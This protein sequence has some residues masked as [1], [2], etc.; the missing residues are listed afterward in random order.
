MLGKAPGVVLRLRSGPL[1]RGD[2]LSP[3]VREQFYY[4]GIPGP[5]AGDQLP[6]P[7]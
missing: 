6:A 3:R 1:V 2:S 4:V 7:G 5:L